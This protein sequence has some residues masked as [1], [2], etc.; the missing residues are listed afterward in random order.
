MKQIIY[1]LL[2]LIALGLLVI[3]SFYSLMPNPEGFSAENK[4]GFSIE[5]AN[6]HVKNISEKPHSIGTKAHS[7]VRNYIVQELQSLGV[8]VQTQKGYAL[9][10][11][12]VITVPENIIAK[13]SGNDPSS[14]NDLMIMTHYDSAVHSSFGASDAGSGVAV[15]LET[16]RVFLKKEIQHKNNI[17]ICFTDAE[18]VGLNG[19]ELFVKEH[20]WA[21][22]IGLVLNFEARGS[23]GP[24]NTILETNS[25]NAKLI[26]AFSKANPEYPMATS[27]MYSVYK[28]LP[29]DTDATVL[30]EQK[31]IPSFFFAFIDDH[32]DYH[33][34][35]DTF[36]NLDQNSLAHQA[37]Y[38]TALM[39]YFANA[40]LTELQSESESVYFNFPGIGMIHYGYAIIIPLLIIAWVFFLAICVY[41]IRKKIFTAFSLVKSIAW[42]L[43]ILIASSLVT[44]FGYQLIYHQYPEY[45][46]NQHGFTSNGH[47]YIYAFVSISLA[48]VFLFY[49]AIYKGESL[50]R[51]LPA[52]IFIWLLINTIISIAFK[53]AAYFIWPLFFGL[54]N[55]FLVIKYNR[56]NLWLLLFFSIPAIFIF[57]P[58]IQFF[59]VGLGLKML[60]V[61]S[62]F[63]VLLIGLLMP[64]FIHYRKIHWLGVLFIIVASIS[65]LMAHHK[66]EF[67]NVNQKPNSLLYLL[68]ADQEKAWWATY[69]HQLDKFNSPYFT[70][71]NEVIDSVIFHSKYNS[72]FTKQSKAEVKPITE[73]TILVKEDSTFQQK[74]T[75]KFSVKIAPQRKINRMEIFADQQVNFYNLKVNG[76]D[77]DYDKKKIFYQDRD[78][79]KLLTYYAIDRDTLSL[80]FEIKKGEIF[81]LKIYEASN[82]LLENKNFNINER[83]Q[84]MMPRPFVLNDAII[85][86]Q[87]LRLNA[88]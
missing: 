2:I 73:A 60:V 65:L 25:G 40:N 63:S 3:L 28:K 38:L 57:S 26:K 66:A 23:G 82:D 24:S 32:Y 64:I 11:E 20:P 16:I 79:E 68:D 78:S 71:E 49:R 36:K 72:R 83:T 55:Y 70:E 81:D 34:A 1:K 76:L 52:P 45:I 47:Y 5:A 17:I 39:P 41:A 15:I 51:T 13:L 77:Q 19:A 43:L 56:P 7:E 22:N 9:N 30:R 46:E 31:N 10:N 54:L 69:D 88:E 6:E 35:N 67:S 4:L 84:N 12:G 37:S 14:K 87:S 58:L 8:Q 27:L 44:Y 42:F 59:P 80:D 21:N 62:L 75:R 53:G 50:K 29:N 74:A 33:T 48:V 18:E 61:S 86:K 85:T